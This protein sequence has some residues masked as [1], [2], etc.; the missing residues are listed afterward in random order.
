MIYR[1]IFL[2]LLCTLSVYGQKEARSWV[3]FAAQKEKGQLSFTSLNDYSYSGYH[4]SE[5][6][7]PDVSQWKQLD[8]TQFGAEPNDQLFDDDGIR[9]AIQ[10]AIESDQPTVVYFP[11]GKYLVSDTNNADQP[12]IINGSNIVLKGAGS[13]VGGTEIFTDKTTETTSYPYRF[14]F[15]ADKTNQQKVIATIEKRIN[16]GAFTIEVKDGSQL[17]EGQTVELYHSGVGNLEANAP[18]LQYKD[19]W[20]I[21]NRGIT[22]VEKHRIIS[23]KGNQITFK[24]PVQYTITADISGAELRE[25][26]TI[27]E[28]GIEDILFT[29][30]WKNRSEIYKHHDSKLVDYA[31]RAIKFDHVQ[32]GWIRNCEIRDWNEC[33]QIDHSIGV[34]VKNLTIAGK[35]GH[36]SYYARYSYGVLFENCEDK[37]PIGF[38]HAGGQGHGPGMRWSTVN[39]VFLNCKM[40]KHQS[41]DCHGYHPYS[42]LLDNVSGGSFYNNGGAENSYPQSGPYMTFWNFIHEGNFSKKVFDFWD[43]INRKN[44]T[45]MQPN[46]IGFQSP[47]QNITLKNTGFEELT[48]EEAYPKSL[49]NAQLQLRLYGG[50]MSGSSSNSTAIFAND[51]KEETYWASQ[52]NKESDWLMLDMGNDQ[53][54]NEVIIDER[55]DLIRHW[56][57]EVLIEGNW[58]RV[59][60]GNKVGAR[61]VVTFNPVS[62]RKI[63]FKMENKRRKSEDDSIKINGFEVKFKAKDT[64]KKRENK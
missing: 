6:P 52:S 21:K 31:Y 40:M 28:V 5:K 20:K 58:Q 13:G 54:I 44:N 41:V 10:A 29:S 64:L 7:I 55:T 37:V 3:E 61:K 60:S 4:F 59:V 25:Y 18:G 38:N 42:N 50:Y 2:Q 43:P 53:S 15:E 24:N 8:V 30:G 56:E 49:F 17:A 39:T 51:K 47:N 22:V 14:Q 46:F 35:Q 27:E 36:T 16:K 12:F 19:I 32:N 34:T 23:I 9:A 1:I 26:T 33:L 57:I 11:A 48:G 63:K 45:Y 62:T